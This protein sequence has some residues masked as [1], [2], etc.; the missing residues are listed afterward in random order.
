MLGTKTKGSWRCVGVERMTGAIARKTDQ[1]K[2]KEGE[3][4][5]KDNEAGVAMTIGR[6]SEQS[7]AV[8]CTANRCGRT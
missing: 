2:T 4:M 5:K 7:V 1:V 6:W 8:I 3:E